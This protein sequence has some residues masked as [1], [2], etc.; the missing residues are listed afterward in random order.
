MFVTKVTVDCSQIHDWD[1][2]HNTVH[3][4]FGFP[5]FYGRNM[6]AWVDC[7]TSLDA[8]DDGMSD[9]HCLPGAVLTLAM[10]NVREFRRRCPE[11]Y[12]AIIECSAFVN[13]RRIDVEEPAI[14]ALSFRASS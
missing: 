7:M 11:Q 5:E 2:F 13:Y 10:N 9:V 4:A 6:D 8:P 3:K 14:L 12:S 1:S